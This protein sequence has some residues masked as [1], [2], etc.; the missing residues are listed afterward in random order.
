MARSGDTAETLILIGL[1]LQVIVVFVLFAAGIAVSFVPIVGDLVLLFAFFG[2]IFVI[3]VY[4]FSYARAREGEYEDARAPTLVFGIL[5]LLSPAL[6][7]GI[8][9]IIAYAMLGSAAEEEHLGSARD[10]YILYGGVRP[11]DR[12]PSY[13]TGF[14]P[15]S[16]QPTAAPFG[17]S[18]QSGKTFCSNCG[19]AVD[20]GARFCSSC[21]ARVL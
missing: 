10:A 9:Y 2:F 5:S 16:G 7:S 3:L 18:P 1:I 13:S 6:I 19:Q 12:R 11:E 14:P 4:V 8:L 15:A 21:G 20:P 17:S